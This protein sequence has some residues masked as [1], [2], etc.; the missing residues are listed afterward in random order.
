MRSRSPKGDF[1]PFPIEILEDDS[2]IS[3]SAVTNKDFR[4]KFISSRRDAL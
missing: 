1:L 4:Q 2:K 3:I